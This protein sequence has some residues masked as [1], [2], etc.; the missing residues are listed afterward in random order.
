MRIGRK[1]L[2]KCP[3]CGELH[4][5]DVSHSGYDPKL[6]THGVNAETRVGGRKWWLFI[7]IIGLLIVIGFMVHFILSLV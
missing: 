3:Q 1:R 7:G 6:P 5:F 2:F 4:R